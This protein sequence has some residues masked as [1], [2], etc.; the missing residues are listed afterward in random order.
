MLPP[1]Y[2]GHGTDERAYIDLLQGA[3]N[4]DIRYITDP[5]RGPFDDLDR[6]VRGGDS[7]G[8]TSRHYLYTAFAAA[9]G[10]HHG[11]VLLDGA[12]GEI[13]PSFHGDGYY[14]ELFRQGRWPRLAREIKARARHDGC[15]PLGLI[16]TLVIAPLI[17][18]FLMTRLRPRFDLAQMEQSM[19]L[20]AD[21]VRRQLGRE[22]P[23]YKRLSRSLGAISP[24]HRRN[25][26][27]K[28]LN[29]RRG[30]P[31]SG[32]VGYERVSPAFPFMDRR[33]LE[34]CLALPGELKVNRGYKR[35][36]IRAGM[37]GILPEKLRWRTTKEPFSPDFHDRYNRQKA[38]AWEALAQGENH[39][40]VQEIV[41]LD[42]LRGLLQ[43]TMQTNRCNTAEDFAAM[44][45]VP[46]GIYLI[47]FL[48]HYS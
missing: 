8:Y 32:F 23:R 21:F 29:M 20:R 47:A 6:L 36:L 48:L 24:S 13:G 12:G 35:Y 1:G 25:Q 28:L 38:L 31:G 37:Q 43:L 14:A 39:P 19:P 4:L 30:R 17:P 18:N 3:E 5:G 33:V 2:Q 42:K 45:A 11:R 15:S 46:R 26:Y 40:A 7:P 22:A 16:K 27:Q 9:A 44:H 41:D 34:F 10:Q